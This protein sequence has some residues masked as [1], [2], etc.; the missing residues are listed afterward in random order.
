M[1]VTQRK[2]LKKTILIL[3]KNLT[4]MK[5]KTMRGIKTTGVCSRLGS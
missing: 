2:S 4:L 1:A 3:M 5:K